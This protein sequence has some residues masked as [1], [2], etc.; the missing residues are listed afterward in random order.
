MSTGAYSEYSI[1]AMLPEWDGDDLEGEAG[2]FDTAAA[3]AAAAAAV[4]VPTA[5]TYFY[6]IMCALTPCFMY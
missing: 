6:Q 4:P 2:A 3:A 1:Q 5:T